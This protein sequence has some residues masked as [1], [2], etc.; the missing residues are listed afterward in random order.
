[1]RNTGTPGPDTRLSPGKPISLAFRDAQLSDVLAAFGEFTGLNIIVSDKVCRKVSL[2]LTDVPWR[3]AFDA[4]LDAYGLAMT[5]RGNV[6]WVAPAAEVAGHERALLEAHAKMAQLAPL[7]SRT[8]ELNYQ[9]AED[10]RSLIAGSGSQRLLSARGAA[11]ADAR[12]NQLFVTD[13]A[14]KLEQITRM[15]ASIDRP[16]RQ[17]LIEARVVEAEEGVSRSLG[18]RLSRGAQGQDAATPGKRGERV[19]HT[20]ADANDASHTSNTADR[21]RID[22]P[23]TALSGFAPG[24]IGLT[25]FAATASRMLD[26]ELSALQAQ[27]HGRIVSSPRVVTADRFKAVIE[28]GTEL[29][30]S[31]K[32]SKGVPTVL[33]RR[34]TLILEVEPQITPNGHI[35]LDLEVAKDSVGAE[36]IAGPAI[37]AKRVRTRV[38]VENGGTVAIGG[39]YSHDDRD[40]VARVPLLGDIPV[41]GALFRHRKQSDRRNELIIFITP[42]VVSGLSGVD[43]PVTGPPPYD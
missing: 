24:A 33:F 38:A 23:A 34:A 7:A 16:T 6:L 12:T 25:L 20:S 21:A 14:P 30:Y 9:R 40:D 8:Y 15:V 2:R 28:Q 42:T 1:V 22:L 13:I 26:L 19:P 37:N 11:N 10:V 4:L 43:P 5:Q 29:P 36:T 17:V 18:T 39:I 27:G 3:R 32:S 35:L 41:L 31:V